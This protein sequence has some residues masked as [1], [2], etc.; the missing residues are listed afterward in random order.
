[1]IEN[2]RR[3]RDL[4]RNFRSL[5]SARGYLALEELRGKE[6]PLDFWA[7]WCGPC[8]ASVPSLRSLN[9]VPNRR[10]PIT[11]STIPKG[12]RAVDVAD[13]SV[14]NATTCSEDA[15]KN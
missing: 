7:T 9:K 15:R 1:M 8:V 4:R 14:P 12:Q 6:V 2:P 3:T 11:P 10:F 5:H 13:L